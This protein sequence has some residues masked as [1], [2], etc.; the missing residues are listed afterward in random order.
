MYIGTEVE[1]RWQKTDDGL[2]ADSCFDG[3]RGSAPHGVSIATTEVA[4]SLIHH[5][6]SCTILRDVVPTVW[7][8]VAPKL[9][10]TTQSTTQFCIF[11]HGLTISLHNTVHC[12]GDRGKSICTGHTAVD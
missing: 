9:S 5:K 2:S 7:P 10:L 3:P 8:L 1:D 11:N 6:A 12:T 4:D